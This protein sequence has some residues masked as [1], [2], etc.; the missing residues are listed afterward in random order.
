MKKKILALSLACAMSLGL[1]AGCGGGCSEASPDPS[2]APSAAAGSST[3]AESGTLT[4]SLSSSPSKLDPIH[5]TGTYESQIIG[6]VCDRLIE[7]NDDLDTY[8]PSLATSWTISEDGSTYVFQIRQGVHFQNGQYSQGREMTAEDVAWSLNRSA[9]YSDMA[10]LS[11]LD[12]AEVTGEWEVTCTLK[13]PNAA[14]LTALTDAGNSII[15]QEEVEG[16]G[17]DFGYHLTGTGAFI[18]EDFQLDEQAVLVAN[19][20]YWLGVPNI[21]KL[22]FRFISDPTQT[23]NALL[24][25]EIDLATQLSGEA[26][27]TVD[28]A[29]GNVSLMK[30]EALQINYVRFNMQNGPT[31]DPLVR[32]ALIQAVDLDAV[33]TALYQYG[34]AEAACLPLPYGSWGYDESLESLALP[35]DVEA[36]KEKLAQSGYPNGFEVDIY[37]SNTQERTTL[38]TLLQAYWSQIGVTTNIHANEWGTFSDMAASGNADIYAMS[39]T[40]YPDPYFFLNNLFSSSQTSSNGNGAL[41]IN[42][43]VDAALQAAVETTDQTE[44]AAYYSEVM[45]H[46]MEDYTG[47]YYAVPYNCYGINSRV[48][49]FTPRADGTLR[50]IVSDGEKIVRNTSVA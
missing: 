37:V 39:W 7:Y 23:A 27:N 49:D 9:Q 17:D 24:A 20:D 31:A 26:I 45:R 10:R 18:M 8:V 43:E 48:Q 25:G 13:S 22:V 35:Y 15:A 30:V 44:R 6:Q 33:R 19:E 5:Y 14:F 1:L 2:A 4:V 11:M 46:A 42:D 36:A 50:F 3:P 34:E 41:Y 21:Q 32:Q 47:I 16:W 12:K 29:G 38:C 40:W 28:Q